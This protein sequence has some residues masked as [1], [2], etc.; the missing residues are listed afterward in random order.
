MEEWMYRS[1]LLDHILV[2]GEGSASC[3][4][5]FTPR[6]EHPAPLYRKLGRAGLD[7]M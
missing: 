4:G 2:V 7:N 5:Q 3:P 6:K 1:F